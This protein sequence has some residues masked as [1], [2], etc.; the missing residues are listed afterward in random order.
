MNPIDLREDDINNDNNI[1][2]THALEP[3]NIDKNDDKVNESVDT[4]QSA[5]SE[6]SGGNLRLSRRKW[7]SVKPILYSPSDKEENDGL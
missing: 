5:E 4:F 6:T 2:L 7:K 3:G 1:E